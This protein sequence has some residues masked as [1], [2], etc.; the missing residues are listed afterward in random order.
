MFKLCLRSLKELYMYRLLVFFFITMYLLP[1]AQD[2]FKRQPKFNLLGESYTQ[3]H[4]DCSFLKIFYLFFIKIVSLMDRRVF[5]KNK[6]RRSPLWNSFIFRCTSRV[7][8]GSTSL[9]CLHLKFSS[10]RKIVQLLFVRRPLTVTLL[11]RC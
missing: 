7:H 10:L 9:Y 11:L 3:K 8:T 6:F 5:L 1:V 2:G 4:I